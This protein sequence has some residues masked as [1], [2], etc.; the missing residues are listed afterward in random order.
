MQREHADL[1]SREEE[2]R[3]EKRQA[4]IEKQREKEKERSRIYLMNKILG[5]LMQDKMRCFC[6][7]RQ[8]EDF[9]KNLN[10]S[11]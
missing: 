7:E 4:W 2:A 6:E 8:K 9:E 1:E 11:K 5:Y 10:I 3:N